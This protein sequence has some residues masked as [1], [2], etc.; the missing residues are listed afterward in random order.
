MNSAPRRHRRISLRDVPIHYRDGLPEGF[1]PTGPAIVAQPN[2]ITLLL[3]DSTLCVAQVRQSVPLEFNDMT[4]D[5]V[6]PEVLGKRV[7]AAAEMCVTLQR[8]GR[9]LYVK[10]TAEFFCAL[11]GLD[12]R[13]FAYPRSDFRLLFRSNSCTPDAKMATCLSCLRRSRMADDV[14]GFGLECARRDSVCSA[15]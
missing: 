1:T 6:T 2:T 15:G 11:A 13:F 3:P 8:L 14:N 5:P 9:R 12:G 7:V 4:L 10:G